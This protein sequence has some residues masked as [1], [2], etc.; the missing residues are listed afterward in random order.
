MPRVVLKPFTFSDGTHLPVGATVGVAATS[1]HY[2]EKVYPNPNQFDGFRFS[3]LRKQEEE[4]AQ[5]SKW[6][7][8]T[9]SPDYVAFGH[10]R[11]AW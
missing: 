8:V 2:N 5:V 4:T 9:T 10:G 7:F 3:R 1:T 11:H 6:R